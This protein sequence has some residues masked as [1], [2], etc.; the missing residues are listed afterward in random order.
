MSGTGGVEAKGLVDC[1][2]PRRR[3]DWHD[4]A[5]LPEG[6]DGVTWTPRPGDIESGV[7]ADDMT[8]MRSVMGDR[9]LAA[10]RD[11]ASYVANANIAL[12]CALVR[13]A[14]E[15]HCGGFPPLVEILEA[16]VVAKER[17]LRYARYRYLIACEG[18]RWKAEA[19]SV[20]VP[21]GA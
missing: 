13:W 14:R 21:C 12:D 7:S 19:S 17:E 2:R 15:E 5:S 4:V 8:L 10:L 20:E 6:P 9:A 11:I 18:V 16:D 3:T 1:V